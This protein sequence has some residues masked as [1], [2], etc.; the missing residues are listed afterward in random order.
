LLRRYSRLAPV[1]AKQKAREAELDRVR[2][3]VRERSKGRCEARASA[4]CFGVAQHPHH[5]RMRSQGGGHTADNLL[6]VCW[7]CHRYIHDHPAESYARGWL[8]R[9]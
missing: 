4:E 9:R 5:R 6:D 8:E 3:A 1:S 2:P 7:P